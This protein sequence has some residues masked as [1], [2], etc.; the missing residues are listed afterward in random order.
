MPEFQEEYR[1]SQTQFLKLNSFIIFSCINCN[2]LNLMGEHV[3]REEP[4][5]NSQFQDTFTYSMSSV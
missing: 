5:L 1:R 4:I 3:F 2:I